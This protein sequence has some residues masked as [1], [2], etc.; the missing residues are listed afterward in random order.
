[1]VLLPKSGKWRLCTCPNLWSMANA[2]SLSKQRLNG[3]TTVQYNSVFTDTVHRTMEG[4][5]LFLL[6]IFWHHTN[7]FCSPHSASFSASYDCNWHLVFLHLS[8]IHFLQPTCRARIST[9][10]STY[11]AFLWWI[12]KQGTGCN[13]LDLNI[14]FLCEFGNRDLVMGGL[15]PTDRPRSR[16]L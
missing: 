11:L 10:H 9:V 4:L 7:S 16:L 3:H 2:L 12:M 1:M 5:P 15:C 8:V 13:W 6:F 14:F